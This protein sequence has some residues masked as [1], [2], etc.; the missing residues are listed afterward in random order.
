MVSAVIMGISTAQAG[1][2]QQLRRSQ[3][4]CSKSLKGVRLLAVHRL[5]L[6]VDGRKVLARATPMPPNS[7]GSR[8]SAVLSLSVTSSG[9]WAATS[10]MMGC[11]LHLLVELLEGVSAL[12]QALGDRQV[13]RLDDV[14]GAGLRRVPADDQQVVERVVDEVQVAPDVVPVFPDID[15]PGGPEEPLELHEPEHSH[16]HRP[17]HSRLPPL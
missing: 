2:S 3:I 8:S 15:A 5:E 4:S 9:G 12:L 14:A 1:V 17:Q 16:L 7:G 6:A 13:L 11:Q 10:S